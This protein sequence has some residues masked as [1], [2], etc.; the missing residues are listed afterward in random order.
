MNLSSKIVAS[1]VALSAFTAPTMAQEK[2]WYSTFSVGMSNFVPITT[3]YGTVN[4]DPGFSFDVGVG[5]YISDDTAIELSFESTNSSGWTFW[6]LS[7]ADT[8]TS[9]SILISPL[10]E[11]GDSGKWRPFIGPSIGTTWVSNGG[12]TAS[13]FAYGVQAGLN[14]EMENSDLVLKLSHVRATRLDYSSVWIENG[15][16]TSFKVGVRF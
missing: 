3:S 8:T 1:T 13:S 10:K 14:Y 15:G 2:D 12:E 11:F 5:K 9:N 16:Y 7:A 4:F 6:N